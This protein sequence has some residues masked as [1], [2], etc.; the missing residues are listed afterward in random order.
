MEQ[1]REIIRKF[2]ALGMPSLRACTVAG[3]SKS[4]YY[5]RKKTTPRGKRPSLYTMKGNGSL[6][7][8]CAVIGEI[9]DLLGLEFLDYGYRTITMELRK[10]GY[11]I[12]KKK[13][14]RLMKSEGLLARKTKSLP[15]PRKRVRDSSPRPQHPFAVVEADL[16]YIYI[17]G[18]KK[19]A[20]LLSFICTFTRMVPVWALGFSIKAKQVADLVNELLRHPKVERYLDKT[21]FKLSLRTDNG[22]QFGARTLAE[23]LWRQGMAHE[24]IQPA[25]PEQ[26]G[27]IESFHNTVKRLVT[28]K[29]GFE[30]LQEAEQT[31]RRFYQTYNNTRSMEILLYNSPVDFLRL[32]EE[33]K[34]GINEKQKFFFRERPAYTR[35]GLPSE[36]FFGGNQIYKNGNLVPNNA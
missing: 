29:Y 1:R 33:N 18:L 11:I 4:S 16:K 32:W 7:D 28:D 21:T 3:I 13:V 25:T 6:C 20:I 27:H 19:N 14:Y 36:A 8:N 24:F 5:Y 10:K 17:E 30:N 15:F 23:A 26:N 2:V 34:I 9:K 12:N 35:P 22:P 31:F